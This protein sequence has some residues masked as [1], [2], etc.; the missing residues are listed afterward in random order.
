L[1]GLF[2]KFRAVIGRATWVMQDEVNEENGQVLAGVDME[3]GYS[4]AVTS[5]MPA[6]PG[7]PSDLQPV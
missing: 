2:A 3:T 6:K 5:K 7:A 4:I 1:G